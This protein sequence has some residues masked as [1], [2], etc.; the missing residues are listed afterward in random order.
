MIRALNTIAD[1]ILI[2]VVMLLIGAEVSTLVKSCGGIYTIAY[3]IWKTYY[4]ARLENSDWV[5][6][7]R[8]CHSD[9]FR[10]RSYKVR[11]LPQD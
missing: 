3:L 8:T 9:V 11:K 7:H 4:Y 10:P 1:Y 6:H 5:P 2:M